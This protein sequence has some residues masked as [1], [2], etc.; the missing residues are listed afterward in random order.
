MTFGDK[1]KEAR[2]LKGYTQRQLAEIIGVAESTLT[3]YEKGTREPDVFKIKKLMAAL[4]IDGNYLF[5]M[6]AKNFPASP[7]VEAGNRHDI[8]IDNVREYGLFYDFLVDAGYVK[9]GRDVSARQKSVIGAV[10]S[11]LD[12]VFTDT[13]EV[14][15]AD[16]QVV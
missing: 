14:A 2:K 7:E 16:G 11:I 6:S 15:G 10:L 9:E 3:G 1:I 13:G 5:E 8:P 4:D 12:T